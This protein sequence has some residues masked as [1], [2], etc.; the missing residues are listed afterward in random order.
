[1]ESIFRFLVVLAALL[2]ILFWG[3]PYIDYMWLSN[4]QLY[5]LDKNGLG[6]EISGNEIAYWGALTIWLALSVG[7]FFY[8]RFARLGFVAF[9][10]FSLALNLFH[11]V[12]VLS[13]YESTISSLICLADG[14]IIATAYL[15]SIGGK[16][17]SGS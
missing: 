10:I 7:L 14:A 4:E 6:G 8:N 16:F 3:M 17:A 11:G 9:Y 15:T 5:L 1:M 13:P 2:S 12:Q